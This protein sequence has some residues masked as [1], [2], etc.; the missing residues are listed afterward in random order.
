MLFRSSRLPDAAKQQ[1]QEAVKSLDINDPELVER[2]IKQQNNTLGF[3]QGPGD[4]TKAQE[5]PGAE[6][7][8]MPEP[9][10]R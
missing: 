1:A 2:R 10:S 5:R 7:K 8:S 9:R 6:R 3:L 4:S